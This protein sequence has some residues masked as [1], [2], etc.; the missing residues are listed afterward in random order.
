MNKPKRSMLYQIRLHELEREYLD[1]EF[2]HREILQSAIIGVV[3]YHLSEL[4]PPDDWRVKSDAIVAR[5]HAIQAEIKQLTPA[6]QI[7][8][9]L[10]GELSF[11]Y[12]AKYPINRDTQL[13]QGNFP[14]RVMRIPKPM[15]MV[16]FSAVTT[17]YLEYTQLQSFTIEFEEW[18]DGR[19]Y[20]RLAYLADTNTLYMHTG[21]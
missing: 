17:P 2:E 11:T 18:S 10:G 1:L 19:S 21:S 6:T 20:Y 7:L 12:Q 14:Y 4:T 13:V 3:S 5:M 15:P 16:S 8:Y 9:A